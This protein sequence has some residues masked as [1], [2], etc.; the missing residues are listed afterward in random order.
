[1]KEVIKKQLEN[2]LKRKDDEK[3]QITQMLGLIR[4]MLKNFFLH[5]VIFEVIVEVSG[6]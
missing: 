1:M 2:A 4:P 3:T 6:V 5:K